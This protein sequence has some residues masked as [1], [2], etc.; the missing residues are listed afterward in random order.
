[1][2]LIAVYRILGLCNNFAYVIMLSAAHDILMP[3]SHVR[4]QFVFLSCCL[5]LL[6]LSCFRPVAFYLLF[7]STKCQ[8]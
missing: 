1:M 6:K 4:T 5:S 3:E 2:R 8:Y 7:T